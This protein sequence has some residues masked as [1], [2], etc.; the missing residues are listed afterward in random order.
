MA[1]Q[2]QKKANNEKTVA[3]EYREAINTL[4][5]HINNLD[6]IKRIYNVVQYLWVREP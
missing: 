1:K 2:T 4:C 6:S 5:S 3:E